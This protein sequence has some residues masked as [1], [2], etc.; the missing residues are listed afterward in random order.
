MGYDAWCYFT[1][2][3]INAWGKIE[4]V[5]DNALGKQ[6][7]SRS[8]YVKK[9]FNQNWTGISMKVSAKGPSNAIL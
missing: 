7:F 5:M 8:A 1:E 4:T 6:G 9:Y 3:A 2:E